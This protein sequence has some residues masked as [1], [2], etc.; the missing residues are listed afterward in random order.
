[1]WE[2]YDVTG[3]SYGRKTFHHPEVGDLS[4][5][6]QSIRDLAWVSPA[7]AGEGNAS[8]TRRSEAPELSASP[9]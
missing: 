7:S 8:L 3:H 1:M 6:Y 5:G 2:R 9:C 4:L